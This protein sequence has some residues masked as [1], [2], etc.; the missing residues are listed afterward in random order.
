MISHLNAAPGL[1]VEDIA[2]RLGRVQSSISH[3]ARVLVEA[4][5]IRRE[6]DGGR[7]PLYLDVP[8]VAAAA[9]SIP[10]GEQ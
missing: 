9:L 7:Y 1:C 5:V 4:G 2:R 8:A 10:G 6:A 3:H